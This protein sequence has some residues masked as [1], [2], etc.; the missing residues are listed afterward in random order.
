MPL[1]AAQTKLVRLA[2]DEIAGEATFVIDAAQSITVQIT[3]SS[4]VDVTIE[5]P[6][7]QVFNGNTI[8]T[9]DGSFVTFETQETDDSPLMLFA[10]NGVHYI[11]VLPS[12]GEGVYT[13]R[14]AGEHSLERE[15]AVASL[16]STDSP[17]RTALVVLRPFVELGGVQVVSAFVFDGGIPLMG[18]NMTARVRSQDDIL[19]I[20]QL[21]DDGLESDDLAGDGI[22][23]ALFEPSEIG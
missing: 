21:Q 2:P 5:V 1:I 8:A 4:D 13:V 12:Q 20:L 14:F 15:V 11:F 16:V 10:G 6:S 17:I 18:A 9:I 19:H 3:A 23:S 7:G 22:Y